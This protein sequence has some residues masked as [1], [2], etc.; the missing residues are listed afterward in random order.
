MVYNPLYNEVG[1]TSTPNEDQEY[2]PIR[3]IPIEDIELWREANVRRKEVTEG[4][5]ELAASIKQI[6]LQQPPIV[7]QEPNGKFKLIIGQ[8][9][10]EA[11][12]QLGWKEIPVLVLKHS[13]D[14]EKAT[15][16]SASENLHRRPVAADD[17][18]DACDYLL[19]ELGSKSKVSKALGVSLPTVTKYL[20]YKGVPEPI[21]KCVKQKLISVSDA[22]RI[23]QIAKTVEAGVAFA[24]KIAKMAKLTRERYF[25]AFMESPTSSW[26][27][28]SKRAQALRQKASL[29][30]WLPEMY[31]RGLAKASLKRSEEPEVVAQT[32][33]IDWLR[34]QGYVG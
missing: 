5:D 3:R 7:Q 2:Q 10:L 26:D 27:D 20:G 8:R 6:G 28:L 33:V 31:A 25:I 12:R 15:V 22:K 17:I 32:A 14:R 19:K 21:K 13:L 18:A 30:I 9:R 11:M 4:L 23:A 16:A 34:E 24:K 29:R 1:M